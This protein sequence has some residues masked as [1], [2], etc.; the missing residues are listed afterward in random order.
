MCYVTKWC[1]LTSLYNS[2]ENNH[3]NAHL[4]SASYLNDFCISWIVKIL[5]VYQILWEDQD[6]PF[7]FELTIPGRNVTRNSRAF[8]IYVATSIFLFYWK[9]KKRGQ[10]LITSLPPMAY[11]TEI[12]KTSPAKWFVRL[13]SGVQ[14]Q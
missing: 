10:S 1:G 7:P 2:N 3:F 12:S 6:L 5:F 8:L 14:V 4:M 9:H 11:H 13:K